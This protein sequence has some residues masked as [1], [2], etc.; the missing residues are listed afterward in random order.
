[1]R[2]SG[3]RERWRVAIQMEVPIGDVMDHLL[4]SQRMVLLSIILDAVV[5]IVF[6]SFLLSRVLVKPLK[7]LVQLTQKISEGDFN[8]KIEVTSK[9][10]I[11][12]L[13]SSFNRMIDRLRENQ[14]N[15]ENHLQS[16]EG[17]TNN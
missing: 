11:G 7:D 17:R 2:L 12:Q 6:G 16:L 14:E 1:M 10:E 8:E 13:I 9:N 15:L 3:S 5:L 4:R